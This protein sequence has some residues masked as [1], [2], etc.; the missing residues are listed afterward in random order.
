MSRGVNG[1]AADERSLVRCY[2]ELTGVSESTA[3]NVFM[4][5]CCP[6]EDSTNSPDRVAPGWLP[7]DL[8]AI[9]NDEATVG[10]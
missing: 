5:V 3:R 7:E 10:K 1:M 6:E 8:H 4:F 2:M 9:A